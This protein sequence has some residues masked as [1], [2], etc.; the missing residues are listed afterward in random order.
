MGCNRNWR[1]CFT[2]LQSGHLLCHCK[3]NNVQARVDFLINRKW[4]DYIVR[5]NPI[6]PKVAELF[7][8]R[9]KRYTLKVVQ[10]YALTIS[11]SEED[12]NS[13][14]NDFDETL[15]KPNHYAI[16]MGDTKYGNE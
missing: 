10:V 6:N 3:T 2:T 8:C 13:F 9:T 11:Y 14:Y 12:I 4:K 16:M 5:V 7:M 1:G 15:R